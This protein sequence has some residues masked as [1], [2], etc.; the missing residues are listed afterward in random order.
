M[1]IIDPLGRRQLRASKHFAPGASFGEVPLRG[2]ENYDTPRSRDIFNASRRLEAGMAAMPKKPSLGQR[3]LRS[4][5]LS[6]EPEY[7][8]PDTSTTACNGV[9][10]HYLTPASQL[11]HNPVHRKLPEE[12]VT[13]WHKTEEARRGTPSTHSSISS[14]PQFKGPVPRR[15]QMSETERLSHTLDTAFLSPVEGE[16]YRIMRTIGRCAT[17]TPFTSAQSED[18]RQQIMLVHQ[19]NVEPLRRIQSLADSLSDMEKHAMLHSL[20]DLLIPHLLNTLKV[21]LLTPDVHITSSSHSGKGYSPESTIRRRTLSRPKSWEFFS[22]RMNGSLEQLE[23]A[24]TFFLYDQNSHQTPIHEPKPSIFKT[25]QQREFVPAGTADIVPEEKVT[26]RLRGGD[27]SSGRPLPFERSARA[28]IGHFVKPGPPAPLADEERVP[29]ALWWLS[30]GRVSLKKKVPTAGELRAR[31]KAEVENR[32]EVGF[33]GTV[34][35]IR[36]HKKTRPANEAGEI[37]PVNGPDSH[38]I[39]NDGQRSIGEPA[40]AVAED[41]AATQGSIHAQSSDD[42][43]D[44]A[45]PG[46]SMVDGS[47]EVEEDTA[48]VVDTETKPKEATPEADESLEELREKLLRLSSAKEPGSLR[49]LADSASVKGSMVV[50]QGKLEELSRKNSDV[51]K[52]DIAVASAGLSTPLGDNFASTSV[53]GAAIEQAEE[54]EAGPQ[55][56]QADAGKAVTSGVISPAKSGTSSPAHGFALDQAEFDGKTEHEKAVEDREAAEQAELSAAKLATKEAE[57]LI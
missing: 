32:K 39:A 54:A 30:G 52:K 46:A 42:H 56:L 34:L 43:P 55:P 11:L 2:P 9:Q 22:G 16:V 51:E 48:P 23:Q 33:L 4:I 24:D 13:S 18:R 14:Q 36:E 57:P 6:K 29:R 19:S 41:T 28:Y 44:S 1:S 26:L 38:D 12:H 49:S 50:D 25:F 3:I 5:G 21:L 53:S 10:G 7:A 35:G 37:E 15:P 20:R 40:M 8:K 47:I 31:R 27:S 17:F 45:I